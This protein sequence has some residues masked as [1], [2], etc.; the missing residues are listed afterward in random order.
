MFNRIIILQTMNTDQTKN[1]EMEKSN[2]E[3]TVNIF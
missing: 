3:C 2:K 1:Y